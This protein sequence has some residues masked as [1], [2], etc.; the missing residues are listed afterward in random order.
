MTVLIIFFVIFQTVISLRMLLIRGQVMVRVRFGVVD[1]VE[2]LF[3]FPSSPSVITLTIILTPRHSPAI[4]FN[5][6]YNSNTSHNPN[7]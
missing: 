6:N 2:A 7:S 4:N 3:L 1:R 5:P